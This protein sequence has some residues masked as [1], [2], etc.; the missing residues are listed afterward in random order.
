MSYGYMLQNLKL[1]YDSILGTDFRT[2]VKINLNV[3]IK[4]VVLGKR[5]KLLGDII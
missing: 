5:D 2:N 3:S 4:I 1:R